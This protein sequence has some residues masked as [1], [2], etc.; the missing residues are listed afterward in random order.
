MSRTINWDDETLEHV[1]H[2]ITMRINHIETGT[3]TYSAVDAAAYNTSLP[4][5]VKAG[6]RRGVQQWA[7]N[8]AKPIPI[9][10]LSSDQ[11]RLIIKL[12]DARDSL[13]K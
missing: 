4:K 6:T 10:A 9:N 13:S 1:A 7:L 12:E 5:H 2:A 3:S 8:L 11:K